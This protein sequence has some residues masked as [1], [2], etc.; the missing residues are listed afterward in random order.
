MWK[1]GPISEVRFALRTQRLLFAPAALNN[2]AMTPPREEGHGQKGPS[3][4]A[5]A[6]AALAPWLPNMAMSYPVPGAS[7]PPGSPQ[8][9][10]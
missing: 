4:T 6:N 9:A 10:P 3:I 8:E 1:W 7:R 2:E 5:G